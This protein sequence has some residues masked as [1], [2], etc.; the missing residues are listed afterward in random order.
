MSIDG[1]RIL[2]TGGAGSMGQA[3]TDYLLNNFSPQ[4]IVIFS[5]NEANQCEMASR[6]G[7]YKDKL[8]FILGSVTDYDRIYRALKGIDIVIHTAALKV[9]PKAEYNPL[10]YV[11]VNVDGTKNVVAACCE[12]QVGKA[13]LL[14]TDKAVMPVNLYGCTKAVAEKIWIEANYLEPIFSV[15]R[16]GNICGSKGSI[17]N[18]FLEQREIGEKE[19]EITDMECTRYWVDFLEAIQLILKA[20][21]D[22]PG[23]ILASKT[24]AFKVRDLIRAVYLR[25]ELKVTGLRE[26]EKI[27]ETLITEYEASRTKDM[28]DYYKIFPAYPFDD[29]ILYDKEGGKEITKAVTTNDHS[30]MMSLREVRAKVKKFVKDME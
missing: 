6:L 16:Y 14:C 12:R 13:I 15:V 20:I 24:K 29:E 23:L 11:S 19:Y 5:R 27:H 1:S 4:K 21:E 26:G 2:I 7:Y 25:A 3:L 22:K 17:I 9:V 8:R 18:H 28:G 10:E 30:S